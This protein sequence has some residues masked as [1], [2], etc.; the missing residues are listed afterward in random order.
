MIKVLHYLNQFFA[1]IGG[2]E[3][4]GQEALFLPH[5]VGVGSVIENALKAHG[6]EYATVVCG[7]NYFHEAEAEALRAIRLIDQTSFAR[8]FSLPAR[9]LTPA[10]TVSPALS[11]AV[12]CATTGAFRR[13][14]AMDENNP[15]TQEIGRHVFVVQTGASTASM[16]ETLKRY[17]LLI[18]KLL[19]QDA[20]AVENFRAEY[21]LAASRA[22]S[23]SK[24]NKP[25]YVRAADLLLAKLNGQ[26]YASEIPQ[27]E[28]EAHAIPN[29]TGNVTGCHRG[30]GDRRRPGAARKSRPFGKFTRLEIFQVFASRAR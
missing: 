1:G 15:G 17:S 29:L 7:D 22:A 4:A 8:T 13:S 11:C 27:I 12:S 10:G 19:A 28:T 24:P 25:D 30:A 18:E 26:T 3:K 5:A 6:V 2:E 9:R 14:P 21:C 16:A 23:R 20:A